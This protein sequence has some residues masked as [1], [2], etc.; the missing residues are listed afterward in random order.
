M[1][2]AFLMASAATHP[3]TIGMI[4]VSRSHALDHDDGL[5]G[6]VL[7][8]GKE[9]ASAGQAGLEIAL[10]DNMI[11]LPIQIFCRQI[12]LR[13]RGYDDHPVLDFGGLTGGCNSGFEVADRAFDILDSWRRQT[14]GYCRSVGF[15]RAVGPAVAVVF[16][17]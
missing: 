14:D 15:R 5:C 16:L 17:R 7:F 4:G 10:R 11:F 3:G 2:K 6:R 1:S 12:L 9:I 13:A 8:S